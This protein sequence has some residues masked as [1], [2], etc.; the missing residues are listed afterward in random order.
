MPNHRALERWPLWPEGALPRAGRAG[1]GKG[2]TERAA[3]LSGLGEMIEVAA[4]CRWADDPTVVAPREELPGPV[5]GAAELAGFAADQIADRDMWTRRLGGLDQIPRPGEGAAEWLPA[6]DLSEQTVWVAAEA[7]FLAAGGAGCGGRWAQ[8]DTNGGAAGETHRGAQAAALMELIERDATGRWW[9]GRRARPL[10]DPTGLTAD[11]AG[12]LRALQDHGL[13]V[14]LFD[15]TTDLGVPV[16]AAV[17]AGG[18]GAGP[19]ALG[20]AAAPDHAGAAVRALCE[21]AQMWL[22]F[23]M[24][25]ERPGLAD[26]RREVSLDLP[27]LS[28]GRSAPGRVLRPAQDG[29]ARRLERAGVRVAFVDRTRSE[30]GIPVWKAISPD[31]CHWKPRFGRPRLLAADDRDLGAVSPVPNPVLLRL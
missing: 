22:L 1:A 18:A 14:L 4:L 13:R 2:G 24:R 28:L 17:G 30:I 16:V 9:Y 11:G 31:L 23:E 29:I 12:V 10:L 26:W 25:G 27:P 6:R 20:A 3:M 8:A 5:W 21:M 7:V 15:I 19:V